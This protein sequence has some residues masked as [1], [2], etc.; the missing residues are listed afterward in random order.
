M[1]DAINCDCSSGNAEPAWKWGPGS[2][3][4]KLT[5]QSCLGTHPSPPNLIPIPAWGLCCG[6]L[7]FGPWL[8][9]AHG[10]LVL[11]PEPLVG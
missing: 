7:G 1:K 9:K 5:Q 3:E 4:Q 2:A 8:A 10:P 6:R 11:L